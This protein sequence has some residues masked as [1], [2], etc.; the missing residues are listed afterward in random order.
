MLKLVPFDESSDFLPDILNLVIQYSRLLFSETENPIS[1]FL[2]DL[3]AKNTVGIAAFKENEPVAFCLLYDFKKISE[4]NFNCYI[5]GASKRKM[6]KELDV[7]LNFLFKD[8]K[9]QGCIV[10]RLETFEYNLPMRHLARRLGFRKAGT[11]YCSALKNGK[12]I[13]NFIYEKKL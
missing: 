3:K 6:S 1:T 5:Y 7:F 13:N 11:L 12:F 2:E 8:L 9:K 4:K 10:L